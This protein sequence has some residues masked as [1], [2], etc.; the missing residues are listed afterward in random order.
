[1]PNHLIFE[2]MLSNRATSSSG[3]LAESWVGL[4]CSPP[5]PRPAEY[6]S[7]W[8]LPRPRGRGSRNVLAVSFIM[9]DPINIW[10]SVGV[11]SLLSL[12]FVLSLY[13]VDPGLP[14]NH[15]ST[16]Y[17]RILAIAAMCAVAPSALYILLRSQVEVISV[18]SFAS[19][20][21]L[22]WSGLVAATC[23]PTLLT[24]TLYAGPIFHNWLDGNP[25]IGQEIKTQRS[26]II[27]RNYVVAPFAEELVYRACMLLLLSPAIGEQYAVLFCPIFFG[28]AHV[29]HLI[30]WYRVSDGT[31]FG[32]ACLTVLV[33]FCYTSIFGL[34]AGFLF[35]RT[36]H[37]V[38]LFLCHSFCNV[39]GLPPL[40]SALIHP[41]KYLILPVYLLGIVLFFSLLFP[42]TAPSLYE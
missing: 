29:H 18:T 8:S 34:F 5:T 20:L 3:I 10:T 38:S 32:Q 35:V 25:L 39:M 13:F 33:Q 19:E 4:A 2:E 15:P 11:C 17:R 21:G 30:D 41:R 16:V 22:R 7:I 40:D 24:L 42:L 12:S 1:M 36:H 26:D 23:Y 14:R 27:L 6:Y 9:L 28:I 31:S 37:L